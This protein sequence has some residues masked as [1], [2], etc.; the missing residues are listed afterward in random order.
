MIRE[1]DLDTERP[2]N[3]SNIPFDELNLDDYEYEQ[4]TLRQNIAYVFAQALAYAS[5]LIR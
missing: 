3:L 1:L 2:V 5:S 4:M